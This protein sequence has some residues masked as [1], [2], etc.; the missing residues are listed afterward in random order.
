MEYTKG[1]RVRH[2]VYGNGTVTRMTKRP[3]RVWVKWDATGNTTPVS[4][5]AV[6]IAA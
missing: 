5:K 2:S 4:L 3:V 1:D 6:E